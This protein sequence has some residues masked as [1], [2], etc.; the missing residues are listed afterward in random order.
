MHNVANWWTRKFRKSSKNGNMKLSLLCRPF[1]GK[2]GNKKYWRGAEFLDRGKTNP[3]LI[4]VEKRRERDTNL[5]GWSIRN[6]T[7]EL[8]KLFFTCEHKIHFESFRHEGD[9]LKLLLF[10]LWPYNS[11]NQVFLPCRSIVM[12]Q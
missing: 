10:V 3:L 4:K 1:L 11:N 2:S 9:K 5:L 8:Y 7:V 12:E 6:S